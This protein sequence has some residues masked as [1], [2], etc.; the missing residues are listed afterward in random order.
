MPSEKY[1]GYSIDPKTKAASVGA[2]GRGTKR[3]FHVVEITTGK[4]LGTY[5]T[6]QQA[7]DA[8]DLKLGPPKG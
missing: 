1:R 5:D 4:S 3:V 8:I 7:V 6:V 2:M